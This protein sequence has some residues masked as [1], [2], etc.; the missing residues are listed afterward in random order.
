MFEDTSRWI[1]GDRISSD[2]LATTLW[3]EPG[4]QVLTWAD[5]SC[6]FSPG[7]TLFLSDRRLIWMKRKAFLL[8]WGRDLI[9][10]PLASVKSCQV[11]RPWWSPFH[12]ALKVIAK[13]SKPLWF[14][15]V[16]WLHGADVRSW[17]R[18]INEIRGLKH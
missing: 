13:D 1:K 4:E 14:I 9:Q 15:R 11:A 6:G 16:H 10:T 18:A 7:G 17:S 5:F 8:D 2:F 3:L 12:A